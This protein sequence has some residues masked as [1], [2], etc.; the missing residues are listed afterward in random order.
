MTIEQ[1]IAALVA[2]LVAGIGALVKYGRDYVLTQADNASILLQKEITQMIEAAADRLVLW[3]EQKYPDLDN[4]KK[5][6]AV[7]KKMMEELPV[8]VDFEPYIEAAVKRMKDRIN[9]AS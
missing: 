8:D 6:Q 3:V 9:G 4:E 1:V 7:I 2:L 5:F